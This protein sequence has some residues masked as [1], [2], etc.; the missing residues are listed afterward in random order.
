MRLRIGFDLNVSML[1]NGRRCL[2]A[3]I[4]LGRRTWWIQRWD[5]ARQPGRVACPL[6]RGIMTWNVGTH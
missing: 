5:G 1:Y 6:A 3:S 2:Y 4:T